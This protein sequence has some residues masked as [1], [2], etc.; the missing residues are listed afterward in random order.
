MSSY[1]ELLQSR[2][3]S[4]KKDMKSGIWPTLEGSIKGQIEAY[5]TV[6]KDIENGLV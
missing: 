1:K 5:K 6:I 3:D 2:I 4:L